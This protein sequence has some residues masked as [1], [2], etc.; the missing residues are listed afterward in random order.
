MGFKIWCQVGGGGTKFQ[1]YSRYVTFLFMV[2]NLSF[3]S[4]HFKK[5]FECQVGGSKFLIFSGCGGHEIWVLVGGKFI[6]LR[7]WGH[8][9][10][11]L[12]GVLFFDKAPK[13]YIKS[14]QCPFGVQERF[15]QRGRRPSLR[16][17][18]WDGWDGWDGISKVSFKN[19]HTLLVYR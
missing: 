14:L 4:L 2:L 18:G 15:T 13:L 3:F 5:N 6:F 8:K 12:V 17:D 19:L 7:G 11:V 9:I 1:N 16:M 10:W